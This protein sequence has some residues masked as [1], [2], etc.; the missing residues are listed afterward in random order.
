MET[1]SMPATLIYGGYDVFV[2]SARFFNA[3]IRTSARS[4]PAVVEQ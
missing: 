2:A 4:A 1:R 3:V